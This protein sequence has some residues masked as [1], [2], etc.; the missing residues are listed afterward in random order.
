VTAWGF[1]AAIFGAAVFGATVLDGA[2]GFD[3]G[4]A[5]GVAGLTAG[6]AAAGTA[7]A[8][9]V[10]DAFAFGFGAG[11]VAAG[12]AMGFFAAFGAALRRASATCLGLAVVRLAFAAGFAAVERVLDPLALAGAFIPNDSPAACRAPWA[13]RSSGARTTT[14]KIPTRTDP[15]GF[16]AHAEVQQVVQSL[17]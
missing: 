10:A 13:V 6:F 14:A 11:G 5:F 16:V 4:A 15:D 8:T 17:S 1:D 3:E 12:L 7:L 9:V 2:A